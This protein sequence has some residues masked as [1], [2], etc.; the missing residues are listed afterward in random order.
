MLNGILQSAISGANANAQSVAAAADNIANVST[1]GYKSSSVSNSTLNTQQS[2]S[3]YSAG[4][5]QTVTRALADVQGLLASSTRSTDLAISGDGYF[6]VSRQAQGGEVL[7]TRDG[8]FAPDSQGNLV[9]AG[10][11][12]LQ[13]RQ[14]GGSNDSLTTVNVNTVSGTAQATTRIAVSGNLPANGAGSGQAG[15]VYTINANVTDSLGNSHSVALSFEAQA[16][17]GY[18]LTIPDARQDSATGPAY[19]VTVSSG[20]D[21]LISGFDADGDGTIDSS[22][23][24]GVYIAYSPSAAADLSIGLDLSGLTQFSGD[25]TV[26]SVQSDGAAYGQVSGVTVSSDGVVSAQFDNGE[27]RAIA[28]IPVATFASPQ[29]LQ[30]VGGNAFRATDAS[31]AVTLGVGGS[32]GAGTVQGNALELSN[33]DLGSQFAGLIVAQTA[34]SASLKVLSAGD[35]MS[36]SLLSVRG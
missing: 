22:A 30:A 17:G 32:G 3:S 35:E 21:G 11:Y 10:G 9:N 18:Q 2:T 31:G 13:A 34:Y 8:S 36:R 28:E 29:G 20:S 24:P 33:T 19:T 7:F 15:D 1:P 5:V 16:G 4:G 27:S 26:G 12:F 25:F 14:P 23:P 6:P